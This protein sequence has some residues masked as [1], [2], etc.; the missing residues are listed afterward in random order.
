[1]SLLF[2]KITRKDEKMSVVQTQSWLYK[3]IESCNKYPQDDLYTLQCRSIGNPLVEFITDFNPEEL[4][5]HLLMHGLFEPTEWRSIDRTVKDM[6]VKKVW[7]KVN[8]EYQRLKNRWSGPEISIFIFPIKQRSLQSRDV[9]PRKNG[10]AYKKCLF[11]FL[12][13]ELKVEEVGALLAHEYNHICRLDH[14][15]KKESEVSLLDSLV[16]EGLGEYSVK[17]L[18]GSQWLAPWTDL[19]TFQETLPLWT[20]HFVP[21]LHVVGIENHYPFLYG[22]IDKRLPKWIGYYI[23]FHIIDTYRKNHGPFSQN[24]S[25]QLSSEEL[26]V[27]SDYP[28][29]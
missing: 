25:Y 16:V 13:S 11:L 18:Y 6:E 2:Q 5:Y 26:V 24:E 14:L 29:P 20:M 15:G 23:G 7:Q 21:S 10:L 17:E 1:M 12:S 27:G 4:H 19:Y 9:L 8:L 3:F 22:D 28:L